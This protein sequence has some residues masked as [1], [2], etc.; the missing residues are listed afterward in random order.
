MFKDSLNSVMT[1]EIE[2]YRLFRV[3]ILREGKGREKGGGG[4]IVF[5][6]I[7]RED[8]TLRRN[9]ME[10]FIYYNGSIK[11]RS[12]ILSHFFCSPKNFIL[13]LNNFLIVSLQ[14]EYSKNIFVLSFI[15]LL[16]K[17]KRNISSRYPSNLFPLFHFDLLQL[18]Q[19]ISWN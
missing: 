15:I 6:I 16:L 18:T 13:M 14:H 5:N 2:N 10:L 7:L 9:W 12:F 8:F 3:F 11:L 17:I 19:F 4:L 1:S